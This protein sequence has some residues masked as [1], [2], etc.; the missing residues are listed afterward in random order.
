L[1]FSQGTETHLSQIKSLQPLTFTINYILNNSIVVKSL[2]IDVGIN[3]VYGN[4]VA[5]FSTWNVKFIFKDSSNSLAF[6]IDNFNLSPGEYTC[7]VFCLVND[8][9]ADWLENVVP[10]SVDESDYYN[11]GK[12]I[13]KN[14]GTILLNYKAQNL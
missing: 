5:W 10:F 1:F 6:E 2:R 3:D 12:I 4:R 11:T 9:I 8:D 13:P 14:Q 7:N